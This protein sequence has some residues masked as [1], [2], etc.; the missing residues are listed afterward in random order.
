MKNGLTLA[1]AG[2][3]G[4]DHKITIRKNAWMNL[5][6][7]DTTKLAKSKAIIVGWTPVGSGF[8]KRASQH[9]IAANRKAMSPRNAATRSGGD[10]TTG[11]KKNWPEPNQQ[12]E[13]SQQQED[14]SKLLMSAASTKNGQEVQLPEQPKEG[15]RCSC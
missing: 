11:A 12:M 5:P 2:M 6:Y 13:G 10:D 7:K 15:G 8:W 14:Q 3:G 4:D 9:P 1:R